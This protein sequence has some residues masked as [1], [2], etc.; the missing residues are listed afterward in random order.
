MADCLGHRG[1][2][3]E[4]YFFSPGIGMGHKRLSIIDIEGGH[5]PMVTEDGRFV[6]LYNGEVY[7]FAALRGELTGLGAAF[8]TRSDTE[9]ILQAFAQWH[10]EA[11]R[12]FRGMY[13]LAIWDARHRALYLARDPL[14]IKP[15]YYTRV[16]DELLF[17][18]EIKALFHHPDVRRRINPLVAATFLSFNNS[19]GRESFWSGIHRCLP[20]ECL[21][22]KDGT[23]QESRFFDLDTLQVE[24]FRGDFRDAMSVYREL[25]A[26]SVKD[27]MIADVP[28]GAY[29]SGGID[30]TSVA[31]LASRQASGS[32]SVFTGFFEGH[33]NGWYDER[34]GA[35]AVAEAGKMIH[36][37]CRITASHFDEC[38]D[39][40]AYH[41]EEPTLG[42]GAIPQYVV[43]KTAQKDVKVVLTGH[44]GDEL[45]AGYPAY[46]SVWIREKGFHRDTLQC[47]Q[48]GGADEWIRLLYF[49]VG[50]MRDPVLAR[51]QLRMFS[52]RSLQSL[53]TGAAAVLVEQSGGI[54]RV[55]AQCKPFPAGNNLDG[56]TRWY[57][58]TY[59]PTLLVQED[60]ISMSCSLEGRVPVCYESIVRFALS[61]SGEIK[62][63]HGE[64]KSLPREAMRSVL[65]PLLYRLPKRGFPTPVVDW[66]SGE[67][68]FIWEAQWRKPLPASLET[69]LEAKPVLEEFSFFRK[70][71]RRLP[72]A[73]ALAH[74]LVSLQILLACARNLEKIPSAGHGSLQGNEQETLP[75]PTVLGRGTREPLFS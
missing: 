15:L 36:R 17:A 61:L 49:L 51:G 8:Y 60:K 75:G 65:P 52:A 13:A 54:D 42:S 7:N 21:T 57:A 62:L 73:Y 35:R 29:L 28:V 23:L 66:L 58:G 59:L 33:E 43:A 22:W 63:R 56:V 26:Q 53:L 46:K 3:D 27:H 31:L 34:E 64:L 69:V 30:S 44:G 70:I 9:V 1:P 50:G 4:G 5:Q 2:D 45:F 39:D 25:L 40:V 72:S 71:G 19:F 12:R 11:F 14:G 32:L 74:R 16:G 38:L 10:T 37:E 41:L 68:G 55:L 24:P 20:G 48:S 18:S 67:L 47:L 6:I